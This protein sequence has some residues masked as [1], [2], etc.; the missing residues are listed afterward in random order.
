MSFFSDSYQL[1]QAWIPTGKSEKLSAA[2][3]A[4]VNQ[5]VVR[6]NTLE[7]GTVLRNVI[8]MMKNSKPLSVKLSPYNE[9]FPAG[10]KINPASVEIS[11]FT[12]EDGELKYTCTAEKA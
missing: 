9:Q 1:E 7:D 6:E 4:Q 11:E 8:F 10:T 3:L 12:N 5:A 2:E